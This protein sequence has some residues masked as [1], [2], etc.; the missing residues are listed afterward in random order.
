V[1]YDNRTDEN[2][3]DQMKLVRQ[4]Q[5]ICENV[6]QCTHQ[7]YRHEAIQY[8]VYW[9]KVAIVTNLL[10]SNVYDYVLF[11]DTD[12]VIHRHPGQIIDAFAEKSFLLSGDAPP[13]PDNFCAGVWGVKN[14]EHGREMMRMWMDRYNMDNRWVR[15]NNSWKCT[16]CSWAGLQYEQ[17]AFKHVMEKKEDYIQRVHWSVLQ[18][19]RAE[20]CC[21]TL[22]CHFAG[23]AKKYINNYIKYTKRE[24]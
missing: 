24:T 7:F 14:D 13:N 6:P 8:P 5:T 11:F 18:F 2:L 4:N 23:P 16:D 9:Q 22:S 3:G 21:Q 1:Q 15:T 10:F 12:A 19:N 20:P 17:G